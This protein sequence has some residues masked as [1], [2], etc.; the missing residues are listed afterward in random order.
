[1]ADATTVR[2]R[3]AVLVA[4]ASVAP[5]G[6]AAAGVAVPVK[7]EILALYDGAQEGVVGATR[8][9][10]FAEMPLNHLGFV[11]R[12]L[13]VGAALPDPAETLRYRGVLTWFAG[14][15]PDSGRYLDWAGRVVGLG[16]PTVILGDVGVPVG[17]DTLGPVNRILEPAG[18]RDSGD[19][20]GPTLGTRVTQADPVANKTGAT[21]ASTA[22]AAARTPSLS[23]EMIAELDMR[24]TRESNPA[25][26]RYTN[27]LVSET[28]PA[29]A[30][31]PR[32]LR[33]S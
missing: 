20:V 8:I 19:R 10:R 27:Q 30:S 2:R 33:V 3:C 13:D 4:A 32:P 28:A 5:A 17:P 21:I 15:V 29:V 9:H 6:E 24:V 22:K 12:F 16:V 25:I 18:V 14:P 11:L 1:M 23:S 26:G 31:D 7:R